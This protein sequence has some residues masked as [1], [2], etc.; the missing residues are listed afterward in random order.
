[1]GERY[2]IDT[3][4]VVNTLTKIYPTTALKFM[5]KLLDEEV[6]ISFITQIELLVV[7]PNKEDIEVRK[8][9]VEGAKV[10]Y[11]NDDIINEAINIKRNTKVALPDAVI[12]ATAKHYNYTLISCNHS[13]FNKVKEMGVKVINPRR[14]F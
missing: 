7:D 3:C 9:F 4:A 12:A 10:E 2:L 5:N 8:Q 14:D 13:D 6:I 11:I 1:M